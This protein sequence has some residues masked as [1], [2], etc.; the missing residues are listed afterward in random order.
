M[1][2]KLHPFTQT[3]F[4]DIDLSQLDLEKHEFFILKRVFERG[5]MDDV[6]FVFR[7][8]GLENIEKFLDEKPRW[9]DHVDGFARELTLGIRELENERTA[10]GNSR[11]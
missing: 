7:H 2:A 8:Y 6:R 1:E 4:W 5:T 9:Y 3:L 11:T 10:L